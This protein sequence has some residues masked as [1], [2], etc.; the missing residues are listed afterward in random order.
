MASRHAYHSGAV[1]LRD[2]RVIV[3]GGNHYVQHVTEPQC[4]NAFQSAWAPYEPNGEDG[5]CYTRNKHY[6]VFSPPYLYKASGDPVTIRPR[7]ASDSTPL[8]AYYELS[9]FTLTLAGTDFGADEIA[10]VSLVRL[11]AITHAFD[12]NTRYIRLQKG[13]GSTP[14][15]GRFVPTP[16]Q[17][18][19]LRINPPPDTIAPPGYYMLFVLVDG[20]NGV[21][22]PSRGRMLRLAPTPPGG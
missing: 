11:G 17:P 18:T 1:L 14:A 12:A 21:M 8:T 22:I 15:E 19:K 3:S 16:N 9:Y 4:G 2:G 5:I 7:I 20:D 6:Q 13:S 10:E